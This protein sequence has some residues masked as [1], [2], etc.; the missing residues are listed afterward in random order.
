MI[1]GFFQWL[2]RQDDTHPIWRALADCMRFMVFAG[3]AAGIM[4][5]G[6]TSFD[7][8]GEGRNSIILGLAALFGNK[9]MRG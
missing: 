1:R 4:W 6:A 3:V 8:D 7:L 9:L 2:G 5:T